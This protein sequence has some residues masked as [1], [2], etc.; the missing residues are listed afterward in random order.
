MTQPIRLA[1]LAAFIGTGSAISAVQAADADPSTAIETVRVTATAHFGFDRTTVLPADQERLL[2]EVATLKDVTWRTVSA[3]G[4]ADSV[5]SAGYNLRLSMRRAQAVR[6]YLVGK[7]LD[8]G[9]I[10]AS[11]VGAAQ[12]VADN[13]T[14]EGRAQ[15]RRA[16]VVFEG[17]RTAPAGAH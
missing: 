2:S 12:P 9:M 5:G 8:P 4:F 10:N 14:A 17:I 11:G 3:K 6:A 13:S 15:N 7:G 1:L 16:E